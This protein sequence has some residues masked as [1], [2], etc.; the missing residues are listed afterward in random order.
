M[1]E[2]KQ[3][4]ELYFLTTKLKTILRQGWVYWKVENTRVETVAEHVYGTLMLAIAMFAHTKP[5]VDLFKVALMLALHE[6]EEILIGDLTLFDVEQRKTKHEDGRKAVR[7][8]FEQ[9]PNAALFLDIIDEFEAKQTPEAKF[10]YQCDKLEA[11]L[12]AY[13]YRNHFSYDKLDSTVLNDT[14]IQTWNKQGYFNAEQL[15]L[16]NDYPLYDGKFL[17]IANYLASLQNIT[18]Q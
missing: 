8:V 17:E 18:L 11:D 15:F 4:V 10:A 7:T 5:Q 3:I 6:T 1:T 2:A 16:L 13:Q 12:Q 9:A 14:R